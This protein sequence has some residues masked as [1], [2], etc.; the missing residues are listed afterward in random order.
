MENSNP[1]AAGMDLV[2][3]LGT[4]TSIFSALD[5]AD[6]RI[7]AQELRWVQVPGGEVLIRQG[8]PGD[9]M[10]IVISG[11][12]Q[13]SVALEDGTERILGE[14][15]R[16]ELVGEMAILSGEPRSATVRAIRDSALVKLSKEAFERI[17]PQNPRAA[18]LI[19]RRLV[20]RLKSQNHPKTLRTLSTVGVVGASHHAPLS[21]F[22][23]RLASSL[24]ELGPTQHLS[25]KILE[26]QFGRGAVM[27]TD[28]AAKSRI[29]AWLDQ[30]EAQ[31]K[32]VLYEADQ[33]PSP[34]TDLC[35]RQADRLL[36][37]AEA[38]AEPALEF[39]SRSLENSPTPQELVLLHADRNGRPANTRQWLEGGR[40]SSHHHVGTTVPIDYDR[41]ARLLTGRA[42]G[43][44]L[45]G[46]GARGL[47]HIGVIRALQE[48]H[49]HIDIIG[50]TSMGAV[51]AA[52][53]AL[54]LDIKSMIEL[55]RKGWIKMDPLKDKTLPI[56]SLLSGRK[57]DQMLAMMFGDTR[58]E[59]LWIKYFSVSVNLTQA[60]TIT[61]RSGS[62]KA[63]VRASA[64]IPGV[65]PA[66]CDRGNLIV[67]GGVLDNLP[68]DIMLE[69]SGGKVIA[70]D[71]SP[72][73]DLEVDVNYLELP[74][75]WQILWSRIN[76]LKSPLKV[77]SVLDVIMRTLM[78]SSAHRT[79]A[80]MKYVDLYLAPPI[81]QFGLFDWNQIDTIVEAGYQYA[82]KKI[83]NWKAGREPAA[84]ESGDRSS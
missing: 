16:G 70:V 75:A 46:G 32:Y 60:E 69:L 29:G 6:L 10:F 63:A 19:A 2:V 82:R 44:A 39:V 55:N 84:V 68:A 23:A 79:N 35:V 1:K 53:Y 22:C 83:E 57:L 11:R 26:N 77:P 80:V 8:E 45:G 59:D 58:I 43:L 7:L 14:I 42:V 65:A 30:Q 28:A 56:V 15:G 54:G 36:L 31:H 18:M 62:L 71:V 49:I 78:L 50:G 5:E 47:A 66:I 40:I 9:G 81:D 64:G 61:N 17:V 27:S 34:W 25:G 73:K 74:S 13:V 4:A 3:L 72:Q 48:A 52:Q 51:I 76:P 67:D 12:F 20:N 37:V 41:L 33:E 24:R 38:T 21:D